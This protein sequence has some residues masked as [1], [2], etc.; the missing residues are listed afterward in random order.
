[1]TPLAMRQRFPNIQKE[2]RRSLRTDSLTVATR[3]AVKLYMQITMDFEK[4]IEDLE[5]IDEALNLILALLNLET[6]FPDTDVNILQDYF[7]KILAA[8]KNLLKQ[9]FL[10]DITEAEQKCLKKIAYYLNVIDQSNFETQLDLDLCPL[11]IRKITEATE[12][13]L[14]RISRAT[15]QNNIIPE[16]ATQT[17]SHHSIVAKGQNLTSDSFSYVSQEYIAERLAGNNWESKT[18]QAYEVTFQMLNC[19]QI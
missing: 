5:T 17:A 16:T 9:R 15:G 12:N 14:I 1:M 7:D 8:N 13:L 18:Q 10:A 19:T 3:L 2:L 11:Y 6:K 4:A